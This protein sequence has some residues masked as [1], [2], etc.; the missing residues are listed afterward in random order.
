MMIQIYY[1]SATPLSLVSSVNLMR[2]CSAPSPRSLTN[3]LSGIGLS[4]ELCGI[5]FASNWT[6]LLNTLF[7]AQ[8]FCKFFIHLSVHLSIHL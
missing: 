8:S 1:I 4:V 5:P 2:A 3:T 7:R 6:F